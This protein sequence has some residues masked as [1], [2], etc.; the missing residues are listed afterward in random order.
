MHRNKGTYKKF[1][2]ARTPYVSGDC[3]HLTDV[4]GDDSD[5]KGHVGCD[6]NAQ[7]VEKKP[8]QT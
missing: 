7:I 6:A 8:G 3:Y 1:G 2:A 4:L 5:E